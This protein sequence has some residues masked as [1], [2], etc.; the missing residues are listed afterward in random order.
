WQRLSL[1]NG[2]TGRHPALALL[3]AMDARGLGLAGT[4][5]L[6]SS[7]HV[8]CLPALPPVHL[9]L[10]QRLGSHVDL[11]VYALNPCREFW[12]EVVDPRRLAT[13]AAHGGQQ[14]HELGNRLLAA[15]GGQAKSQLGL[16]V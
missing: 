12:F 8:F 7:A 10:L 14:Y 2:A 3:E 1:A 13:L 6:P 5:A 4:G 9:E 11:H 15:W 16:L